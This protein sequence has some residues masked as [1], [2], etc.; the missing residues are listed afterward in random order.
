LTW[1]SGRPRVEAITPANLVPGAAVTVVGEHLQ[2][3]SGDPPKIYLD[4]RPVEVTSSNG[5][6][7]TFT[8][9]SGL[10]SSH[11]YN[12][13]ISATGESDPLAIQV[14]APAAW[15]P[16]L[17]SARFWPVTVQ[18]GDLLHITATVR[19]N[20][21]FTLQPAEPGADHIYGESESF[22]SQGIP[23]HA[24]AVYLRV[25]SDVT[26]GSW[27]YMW[28]LSDPLPPG[29]TATLEGAIRVQT[30]GETRYRVGLVDGLT[31]FIDDNKFITPIR[32]NPAGG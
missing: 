23:E 8:A 17:V 1:G 30:A 9:P 10:L 13:A 7:L 32:I 29:E 12:L 28:G 6:T 15:A 16:H 4:G 27:P 31:R 20:A 19:N 3:A 26:G 24:G 25:T 5:N 14:E 21:P 18:A 2:T 22:T 11:G